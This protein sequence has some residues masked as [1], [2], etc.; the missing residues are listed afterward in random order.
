MIASATSN[1]NSDPLNVEHM[2]SQEDKAALESVLADKLST[3]SS[4]KNSQDIY[5]AALLFGIELQ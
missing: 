5:N 2:L 4:E 3:S 1:S